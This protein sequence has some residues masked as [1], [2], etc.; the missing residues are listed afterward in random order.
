MKNKYHNISDVQS[1]IGGKEAAACVLFIVYPS[2][3]L[4]TSKERNWASFQ[5]GGV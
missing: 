5:P 4:S 3:V 1:W 2:Q